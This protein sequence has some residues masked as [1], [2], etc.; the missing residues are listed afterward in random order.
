MKH[1]LSAWLVIKAIEDGLVIPLVMEGRDFRGV[2][3][4]TGSDAVDGDEV[5]KLGVA[6]SKRY[7]AASGAKRSVSSIDIS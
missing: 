1:I 7:F 2:Q 3:K 4:S 6:V 5:S